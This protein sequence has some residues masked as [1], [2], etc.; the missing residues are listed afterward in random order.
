M[1][2]ADSK[3]LELTRTDCLGYAR[4]HA[5]CTSGGMTQVHALATLLTWL[6][7]VRPSLLY[8]SRRTT[9]GEKGA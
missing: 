3:E 8:P 5:H 4:A 7:V 1:P 2:T 6:F 9:V